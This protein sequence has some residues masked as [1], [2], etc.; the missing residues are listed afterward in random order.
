M[1]LYDYDC[2]VYCLKIYLDL[3]SKKSGFQIK[4]ILKKKIFKNKAPGIEFYPQKHRDV[5]N[6]MGY[7]ENWD[8]EK[9][10]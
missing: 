5:R 10:D 1:Q 2:T 3:E 7:L 8:L 9:T 4:Q 6:L